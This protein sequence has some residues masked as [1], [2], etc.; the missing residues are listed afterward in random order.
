MVIN[1]SESDFS[2]TKNRINTIKFNTMV[3]GDTYRTSGPLQY[4][5]KNKISKFIDPTATKYAQAGI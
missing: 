5:V 1:I 3:T 4:R 2:T